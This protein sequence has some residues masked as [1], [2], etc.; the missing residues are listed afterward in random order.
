MHSSYA[1]IATSRTVDRLDENVDKVNSLLRHSARSAATRS[2]HVHAYCMRGTAG[3]ESAACL[4]RRISR[5]ERSTQ[6]CGEA[7]RYSLSAAGTA[8]VAATEAG[9]YAIDSYL[10]LFSNFTYL[11]DDPERATS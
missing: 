6:R 5:S 4:I 10:D 9:V 1:P 11:L 3:P 8:T 7:S 2:R